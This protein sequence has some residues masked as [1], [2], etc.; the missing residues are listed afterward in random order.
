MLY[1]RR[2]RL[3]G[4]LVVTNFSLFTYALFTFLVLATDH[5]LF[6]IHSGVT[7]YHLNTHFT[8]CAKC[9][10]KKQLKS[11]CQLLGFCRFLIVQMRTLL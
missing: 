9:Y 10:H 1:T 6:L 4:N 8:V 2:W 7:A 11:S 3:S 5:F